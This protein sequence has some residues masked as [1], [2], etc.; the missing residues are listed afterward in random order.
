MKAQSAF[1]QWM[2]LALLLAA[3]SIISRKVIT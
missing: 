1:P 3:D 2:D